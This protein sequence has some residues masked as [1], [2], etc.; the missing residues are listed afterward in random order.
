MKTDLSFDL[1]GEMMRL[2][3]QYQG[4]DWVITVTAVGIEAGLSTLT[5]SP[6]KVDAVFGPVE[7]M[8]IK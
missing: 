5:A 6:T 8:L 4:K 2:A 1:S 3:E 7:L